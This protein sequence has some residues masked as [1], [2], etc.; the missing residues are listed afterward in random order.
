M[1]ALILPALILLAQPVQAQ[2]VKREGY[3]TILGDFYMEKGDAGRAMG[4]YHRASDDGDIDGSYKYACLLF[5]LSVSVEPTAGVD[6]EELE[7]ARIRGLNF[8]NMHLQRA[9]NGNHYR[10]FLFRNKMGLI[11]P[12]LTDIQIGRAYLIAQRHGTTYEYSGY[13]DIEA[14]K[15]VP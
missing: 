11:N 1:R 7:E 10:A 12:K 5:S 13:Y 15:R 3:L 8:A 14:G 9:I 2:T 6:Q 4:Y